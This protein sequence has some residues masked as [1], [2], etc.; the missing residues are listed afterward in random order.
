M[1]DKSTEIL[2]TY[3]EL[4]LRNYVV[5]HMIRDDDLT[6]CAIGLASELAELFE[7]GADLVEELG[8]MFNY[9][10]VGY[11]GVKRD[12]PVRTVG[13]AEGTLLSDLKIGLIMR[14]SILVDCIKRR[15]RYN[16]ARY[17]NLKVGDALDDVFEDLVRICMMYG[18][19]VPE[20]MVANIAK[21][22]KRYPNAYTDFHANARLD[23][24]TP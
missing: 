13:I 4:A 19:S 15:V 24:V 10:M 17:D 1:T 9:C 14:V 7:K 11:R 8:D 6:H 2:N 18:L 23:K 20:I 12:F 21:L 3:Q 5:H 16:D 22:A